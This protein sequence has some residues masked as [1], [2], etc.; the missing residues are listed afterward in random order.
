M[1]P[2]PL[3]GENEILSRNDNFNRRG[4]F[5]PFAFIISP[6]CYVSLIIVAPMYARCRISVSVSI[7]FSPRPKIQFFGISKSCC[8][9]VVPL[10][11]TIFIKVYA[12]KKEQ[13]WCPLHAPPPPP[14]HHYLLCRREDTQTL[15]CPQVQWPLPPIPVFEIC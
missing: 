1:T 10:L 9:I 15:T 4:C 7:H 12:Y 14:S 8:H 11:E 5:R 3:P 2:R 6:F 13:R